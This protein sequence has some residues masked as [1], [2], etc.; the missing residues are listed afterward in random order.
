[1]FSSERISR[2][3][4]NSPNENDDLELGANENQNNEN[5][6]P[7][8]TVDDINSFSTMQNA[9]NFI[10]NENNNSNF[11]LKIEENLREIWQ[12]DLEELKPNL[13]DH[14]I[15]AIQSNSDGKFCIIWKFDEEIFILY[16]LDNITKENLKNLCKFL[17]DFLQ[18]TLTENRSGISNINKINHLNVP[19][20]SLIDSNDTNLLFHAC[21]TG[22]SK[23]AQILIKIN[24]DVNSMNDQRHCPIDIAYG[25]QHFETVL[26]LLKV[27][28]MFPFNFNVENCSN[29]IKEFAEMSEKFHQHILNNEIEEI[30][31]MLIEHPN[32]RYFYSSKN[33]SALLMAT[34]HKMFD[35]YELLLTQNI[36][37][38]IYEDID[39]A[40]NHFTDEEKNTLREINFKHK[41]NIPEEKHLTVLMTKISFGYD[42]LDIQDKLNL[43]SKAFRTLNNF[44]VIS[45]LLKVA[46]MLQ[47]FNIVFDFNRNSVQ[48]LDPSKDRNTHGLFYIHSGRLLIG[49][50]QLLNPK[51]TN[52]VLATIAHELCHFILY[53]IFGNDAKPYKQDD[54]ETEKEFEEIS[55]LYKSKKDID[56]IV[57]CVYELYDEEDHHA[58]LIVRVPHFYAFYIESSAKLEKVKGEF[59]SLFNFYE[60]KII[61]KLDTELEK[62][63]KKAEKEK[64][65]DKMKISFLKKLLIFVSISLS[66]VA[67]LVYFLVYKKSFEWKDL[68]EIEKEK[69]LNGSVNFRGTD[70]KFFEI[71]GKN[72][73]NEIFEILQPD[74]I[75]NLFEMKNLELRGILEDKIYLT[76]ENMTEKLKAKTENAAIDFQGFPIKVNELL[77]NETENF[78][79]IL[80]SELIRG[81]LKNESQIKIGKKPK[82]TDF[83]IERNFIDFNYENNIW[84]ENDE[85]TDNAIKLKRNFES[86]LKEVK[87]SKIFLLSDHAGAGKSTTMKNLALKIKKE[88]PQNWVEFVDLKRHIGIYKK[89]E[90]IQEISTETLINI[91]KEIFSISL[92]FESKVFENHFKNG[93]VVLL[94]DGVDEIA[95]NYKDFF[96]NFVT[97]I[98]ELTKN[99]HWIATR[100]QHIE[101][102]KT[103]L[104]SKA[105]KLLPFNEK[106]AKDL[107]KYNFNLNNLTIDNQESEKYLRLISNSKL[108]QKEINPLMIKMV[109]ELYSFGKLKD[110][111]TKFELYEAMIELKKEILTEKGTIANRDSNV[112]SK[113][114]LWEVHQIYAMK[115]VYGEKF[116]D[117]FSQ[118]FLESESDFDAYQ[119]EYVKF[120]QFQLFKKLN[121]EKSKWSVEAISRSGFLIVDNWNTDKEFPDFSHQ[122]FAEFFVSKFIIETIQEALEDDDMLTNEEIKLRMKFAVLFFKNFD[123]YVPENILN[124]LYEFLSSQVQE[125]KV[126]ENFLKFLETEKAQKVISRMSQDEDCNRIYSSIFSKLI[127][128]S[129]YNE[130][131]FNALMIVKND[132]SILFENQ[133]EFFPF[134]LF[135]FYELFDIL[136]NS[137]FPNWHRFLGLKKNLDIKKL[138]LTDNEEIEKIERKDFL[139]EEANRL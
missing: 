124:F 103:V 137:P 132:E 64:H 87:E 82:N 94:L 100:P 83:F 48:Y 107:I 49:A 10:E 138:N 42:N 126:G 127:K 63:K 84:D 108:Y 78:L 77:K 13:F 112:E 50:K 14:Q 5:Q 75:K 129:N 128:K 35:V 11:I 19:L 68:N 15:V 72:E 121:R 114:N 16:I 118:G 51:T 45:I 110:F 55:E 92:S 113:I 27:N 70:L 81:L 98:K 44:P 116:E 104:N 91:L 54:E 136:K 39:D 106:Q 37:F 125:L 119:E 135:T 56:N 93:Q 58:E 20:T 102:L 30:K 59:V 62:L 3:F 38:S 32:L 105:Y 22:N 88:M 86:I 65:A 12:Y 115:L 69:V 76:Y 97:V 46:A 90:N 95:P 17:F 80:N 21:Q 71:Y 109:V 79:L 7:L 60:S 133:K 28:S 8:L 18:K 25:N 53:T 67:I 24:F 130:R 43:V 34:G 131:L 41:K 117:L 122:T 139:T 89:Y 61:P 96:L 26:M 47:N 85:M 111:N 31:Q 73:S 33:L 2:F 99:Q 57:K 52:E 4:K 6:L 40:T 36:Y 120:D 123:L 74:Q 9:I 23:I 29:E 1:M 66:L 134:Y 101:E